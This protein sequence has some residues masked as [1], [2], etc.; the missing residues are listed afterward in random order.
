MAGK[1]TD[2]TIKDALVFPRDGNTPA[3]RGDVAVCSGE[4]IEIGRDLSVPGESVSAKGRLLLP[5]LIQ[6]H[7]HLCQTAFRGQAEDLSLLPWLK[8]RIWPLEAA[9]T[10]ETVHQSA[11]LGIREL[12]FSGVTTICTMETVHHS[13]AVFEACRETGIR[14]IIGKAL[15]DNGDDVPDGLLQPIDQAMQELEILHSRYHGCENDRIR[16]A[17]AP[18]FALSCSDELLRQA[19]EFAQRHELLLHTHAAENLAEIA[20]LKKI[21]GCGNIEYLDHR[22]C[23][24]PLTLLAHVVWPQDGELELIKLRG[25]AIVHCPTAN[26]KLGS[27]IAPLQAFIELGIRVGLGSDGAACNNSLDIWQEMK[28]AALSANVR[29]GVGSVSANEALSLATISGAKAVHWD[30]QIGSIEVGKKADLILV[31]TD[32]PHWQGGGDLPTRIVYSGRAADVEWVM[33]DGKVLLD[34]G[35]IVD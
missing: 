1:S 35:R 4:I 8:T 10:M 17:V 3:F 28:L 2:F 30:D 6:S 34:E 22:G 13:E 16:V 7:V 5:G 23:L 29:T 32:K 19:V 12:L 25:A 20:I 15:M 11:L 26:L 33:V 24:G 18:R 21:A 9:H 31:N 27:G 14:A